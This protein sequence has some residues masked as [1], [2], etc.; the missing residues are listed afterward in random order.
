MD[1]GGECKVEVV[2]VGRSYEVGPE[3]IDRAHNG[4][5]SRI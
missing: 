4:I 2:H 5:M 1:E 3:D